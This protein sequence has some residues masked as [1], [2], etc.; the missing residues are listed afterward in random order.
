MDS[1]QIFPSEFF[2]EAGRPGVMGPGSGK[3]TW[4]D[5][6]GFMM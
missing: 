5:V 3:T 2:V 4:S 6:A 1:K